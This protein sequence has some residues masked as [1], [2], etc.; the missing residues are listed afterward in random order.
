MT[1]DTSLHLNVFIPTTGHHEAS[2][3]HPSAQPERTTEVGYYREIARIAERGCFDSLFLADQ[4]AI[5][6]SVRHVAQG[7][8]EPL[9]LL[10]ALA[11]AT[12]RIGLIATAST[13]LTSL[14]IWRASLPRSIISAKDVRAGI[15]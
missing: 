1:I 5:G 6:R 2:W 8:L 9:T 4:L 12:E 15:S 7:K 11:G 14:I 3:L 13:T 10:S